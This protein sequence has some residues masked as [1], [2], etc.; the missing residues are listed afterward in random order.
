MDKHDEANNRFFL[1][2]ANWQTRI[3]IARLGAT[4]WET[5]KFYFIS[6]PTL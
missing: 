3:K 2:F 5:N 6:C 1:F 4:V